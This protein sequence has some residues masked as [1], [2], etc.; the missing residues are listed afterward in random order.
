MTIP[1]A[2]RKVYTDSQENYDG[3]CAVLALQAATGCAYQDARDY[4]TT[5]LGFRPKKGTPNYT[6]MNME[7]MSCFGHTATKVEREDRPKTLNQAVKAYSEGSYFLMV[8]GHAVAIKDGKLIDNG[9]EI[10]PS[11][12][13][14][15]K[16][17]RRVLAAIKMTP[18]APQSYGTGTQLTLTF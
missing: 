4:A 17:R 14:N 1:T 5:K 15:F 16:G 18:N 11:N 3:S 6:L 10:D 2:P 8:K 13:H 9:Y 7:K 12:K